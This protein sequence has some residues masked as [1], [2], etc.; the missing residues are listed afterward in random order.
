MFDY[1]VVVAAVD[2]GFGHRGRDGGHA[3]QYGRTISR[4]SCTSW[5][6][7]ALRA[8][9]ATRSVWARS[10]PIARREIAAV[11][12]QPV[13]PTV[14][15]Q[16]AER[17]AESR[18]RQAHR[19]TINC[20]NH[21]KIPAYWAFELDILASPH[22]RP[23]PRPRQRTLRRAGVLRVRAVCSRP[24][25]LTRSSRPCRPWSGPRRSTS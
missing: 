17:V 13:T 24:Q 2:P 21:P 10:A 15:S 4:R 18:P 5:L 12:L 25:G 16:Q 6:S 7:L 9:R 14:Q 11:G 22:S 8:R 3:G 20:A 23:L 1:C 19:V